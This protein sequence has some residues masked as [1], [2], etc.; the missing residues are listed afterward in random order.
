MKKKGGGSPP[1][2]VLFRKPQLV[3]VFLHFFRA[4]FEDDRERQEDAEENEQHTDTL[5]DERDVRPRNRFPQGC[6]AIRERHEWVQ[7]LEEIGHEL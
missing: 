3:D 7:Y 6:D 5:P 4:F 1:F 2:L